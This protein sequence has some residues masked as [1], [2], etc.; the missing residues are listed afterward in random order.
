VANQVQDSTVLSATASAGLDVQPVATAA[1]MQVK[2]IVPSGSWVNVRSLPALDASIIDRID[3]TAKFTELDR[4]GGW[5]KIEID[6][7]EGWVSEK[8]APKEIG[9]IL[10]QPVDITINDTP[11]GFLRVRQNPW[12]L[13]IAKV[14]P[15]DNFTPTEE[16][17]NWFQ[18]V[19]QDGS[20]GWIYGEYVTKNS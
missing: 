13:E 8:F 1:A 7:R 12:G 20:T 11:T 10:N 18:I 14:H 3:Q 2:I 4:Q 19:L 15:G 5:V 16:K 9:E 17:E 6:S